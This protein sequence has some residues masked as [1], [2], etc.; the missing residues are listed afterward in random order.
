MKYQ[1]LK[2]NDQLKDILSVI[3]EELENE[4]PILFDIHKV[5]SGKTFFSIVPIPFEPAR[6]NSLELQLIIH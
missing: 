5:L 6:C 4:D 3:G 2:E 1:T